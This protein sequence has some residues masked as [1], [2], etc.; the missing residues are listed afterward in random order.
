MFRKINIFILTLT[1]FTAAVAQD[2]PSTPAPNIFGGKPTKTSLE[3]IKQLPVLEP[4]VSLDGRFSIGLSPKIQLFDN[5]TPK[6]LGFNANGSEFTWKYDEGEIHVA[7]LDYSTNDFK[8]IEIEL[9]GLIDY[10]ENRI[11]K[12]E[13][14]AVTSSEVFN[15][16]GEIHLVSQ[17]IELSENQFIIQRLY[18]VNKRIYRLFAIYNNSENAKFVNAAFDTFKLISQTEI[19]AEIQKKY[20]ETRPSPLPQTPNVARVKSD[21]ENEGLKGKVKKVI[22]ESEDL[23]GKW[24]VQGRKIYGITYFNEQGNF[25]Q[26]DSYNHKG[27]PHSITVYG[28]IAGKRVSNAKS[29]SYDDNPTI[30]ISSSVSSKKTESLKTDNRYQLSYEFKYLEGKLIEMI[31]KSNADEIWMR[32]KYKYSKNRVEELIYS[33]DGKINQH[34]VI[35]FDENGNEIEKTNKDVLKIY[36]EKKYRYEY[37]FDEQGNWI[38]QTTFQE[39]AENGLK[40]FKPYSVY[41]RTIIYW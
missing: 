24:I 13:P 15:K 11:L 12:T 6:T 40:L 10:S 36:G 32:Y 37:E 3:S 2:S 8:G 30:R 39:E 38:K 34:Y 1:L 35:N 18:G 17:K 27:F 29:V 23:S 16:N 31:L 26:R 22:T 19:D 7:F 25:T 33:E 14:N 41:Y 28:Y 20:E 21:A 9:K 5:L 4:F